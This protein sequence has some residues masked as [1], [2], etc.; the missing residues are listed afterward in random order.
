MFGQNEIVGQKHFPDQDRLLITSVFLTIQGEGPYSGLPAV[1]VRLAKCNLACSFCD[2]YFDA[3]DWF[4]FDQLDD[5]I[6]DLISQ[7]NVPREN[8]VLVITGGEPMLQKALVPFLYRQEGKWRAIQIESNGIVVQPIPSSVT[9]VVS[10]K[11]LEVDG[12]ATRYIRPNPKM[13]ERADHL[14]FVMEHHQESPYSTVPDWAV[15]WARATSKDV[16]VSPI[17]VYN[18]K[19]RRAKTATIKDRSEIEEVVSFWEPGLLN[20]KE[21]ERN[22]LY[23]ARYAVAHGLRFQVQVHLYAGLA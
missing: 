18:R 3:G 6:N 10:P 20:L 19:P 1:F 15:N 2:T 16:F 5:F 13:L 9:L 21:N 23:T 7:Q 14:K 11:C 4:T 12:V 17:N 8:L 22:H